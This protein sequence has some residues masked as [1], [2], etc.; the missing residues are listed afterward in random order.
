MDRRRF[1]E[2]REEKNN[3]NLS[4]EEWY[5]K[6]RNLGDKP[7]EEADAEVIEVNQLLELGG[8][9]KAKE[10]GKVRLEG[11]DYVVKDGDVVEFKIGS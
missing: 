10:A 3:E 8:W 2:V 6:E 7:I 11:R 4:L 9:L 5:R 1:F